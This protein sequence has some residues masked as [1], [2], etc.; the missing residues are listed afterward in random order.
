MLAERWTYLTINL[1]L[2]EW[3][4]KINGLCTFLHF[5]SEYKNCEKCTNPKWSLINWAVLLGARIKGVSWKIHNFKA[6]RNGMYDRRLSSS[7]PHTIF[8]V[9]KLRIA[10]YQMRDISKKKTKRKKTNTHN[11]RD[12]ALANWLLN[13]WR[14]EKKH[15]NV[16]IGADNEMSWMNGG[17]DGRRE[18]DD[19]HDSRTGTAHCLS[20]SNPLP[21]ACRSSSTNSNRC[22]NIV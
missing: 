11:W 19:W 5:F 8:Q 4:A 12:H 1:N 2:N 21:T 7:F 9:E 17:R 14:D 6:R 18:R 20:N 13:S 16:M 22:W 15:P 10:N 3:R